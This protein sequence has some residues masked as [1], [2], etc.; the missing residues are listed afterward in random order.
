[1]NYQ[2]D[3]RKIIHLLYLK[4]LQRFLFDLIFESFLCVPVEKETVTKVED[5]HHELN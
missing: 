1:M 2:S 5:A 3:E 4:F